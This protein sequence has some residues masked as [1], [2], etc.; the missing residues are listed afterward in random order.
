MKYLRSAA[1]ILVFNLMA[2]SV[3]ASNVLPVSAPFEQFIRHDG[4]IVVSMAGDS[5]DPYFAN[6]AL[7]VAWEAGLDVKKTTKAWL[8]WLVSHQRGDGGFDRFCSHG[9]GWRAC[10]R[11]DADDS[12]TASFL[13]LSSLYTEG[14]KVADQVSGGQD[15]QQK[16]ESILGLVNAEKKAA[17]LL[18]RLRT[19]RGTYRAFEHEPIEYLMDNTE[20]YAGLVSIKQTTQ[21]DTLKRAIY[22]HFLVK[23]HWQPANIAY[24]QF[25]FYPSALAPTYLW[26]TG[27]VD[28]QTI[29]HQFTVWVQKW[30]EQWLTRSQDA[31]AWGLVAWGARNAKEQHW[32][33]CWRQ[34]YKSHDRKVGW[35]V[36]DEAVDLGLAHLGVEAVSESCV[37]VL[38]Q[39]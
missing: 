21:A 27:L 9:D 22:K 37:A 20:V 26:H 4:A 12:S 34:H 28:S 32:I 25:D 3:S 14:I 23:S 18:N 10:D 35:T 31:Y 30:G 11:A 17:Q 2:L 39:K 8:S 13:H 16:V 29:S 15:A 5:V 38:K 6:K 24:K 7:I 1:F 19:T 33:R 36:I